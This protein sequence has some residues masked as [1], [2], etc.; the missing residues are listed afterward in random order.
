MQKRIRFIFFIT[1]I[2]FL[3]LPNIKEKYLFIT[4]IYIYTHTHSQLSIIRGNGR[5]WCHVK[6]KNPW[7]ICY[8]CIKPQNIR[9]KILFVL[10]KFNGSVLNG[11]IVLELRC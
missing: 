1:F 11:I 9:S 8:S 5:D 4:N 7:M 3:Y 10:S 6:L 2:L